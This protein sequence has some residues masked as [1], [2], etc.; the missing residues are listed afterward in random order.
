M[1]FKKAKVAFVPNEINSKWPSEFKQTVKN[2]NSMKT[3][4]IEMTEH[5]VTCCICSMYQGRVYSI[6]GTSRK[7]PPLP[8][9]ILQNG[10][11]HEG[12]RHSF[13]PFMDGDTGIYHKDIVRFSNSPFVDN[14]SPEDVA[15]YEKEKAD[16]LN[17]AE[18]YDQY[19]VL[20][21]K[22][23]DLAPKSLSAF[24]RMHNSNSKGYQALVEECK[25]RKIKI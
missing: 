25:K 24:S 13:H 2:A 10:E 17:K 8:D 23:P 9:C 22:A 14:R 11:V 4:L 16:Q 7:Y 12:C 3:D 21:K 20:V 6:S 15:L 18:C 1:L 5:K 19:Q